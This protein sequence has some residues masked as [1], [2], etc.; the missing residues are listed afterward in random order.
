M[1][2][3][4]VFAAAPTLLL[5]VVLFGLRRELRENWRAILFLSLAV[6]L[7]FRRMIFLP[8]MI[9]QSDAN[10][11]Q[12]QFFSVYREAITGGAVP[13]WNHY[14]GAGLPNL[15]HPLSAM[16][17]PLTPLFLAGSVFKAMGGFIALH[18]LLAGLFALLLGRRIFRTG[19]AALAFALLW[20]FNGWAVT[21]AGHQPAIEYLFA[22]AWLPMAALFFERALDGKRLLSSAAGAG[23]GLAWMGI[24][25]PNLFVHAC[26]LLG[27][28]GILRVAWLLAGGRRNAAALA[29]FLVFTAGSFAVALSAVEI[30]PA[31]ELS[32]LATR[33]RLGE[34]FPE[35]WRGR[36]LSGWEILRLYFPYAPDRPFAVYYSPGVLALVGALYA[37]YRTVRTGTR[38]A[39][40]VS[41][42]ALV[43]LGAALVSKG[44]LY[45]GFAWLFGLYARASL[46]PAGLLL[47][48]APVL[49]LAALGVEALI[50]SRR[51]LLGRWGWVL[52]LLV[53]AE[54]FTV[55]SIIYPRRGERRLTYDYRREVADFPHL[56]EVAHSGEPGRT[57]VHGPRE[58]HVL[59]PSY[60]MFARGLRR[61]NLNE[62][63]FAP[64][65]LTEMISL[66]T[67]ELYAAD[68]EVLGV[69]FVASTMDVPGADPALVVPWPGC[70]DHFENSLWWPLRNRPAWLAWDRT[71]RLYRVSDEPGIFRV[72]RGETLEAVLGGETGMPGYF[73]SWELVRGERVSPNRLEI[74]IPPAASGE[75]EGAV[76]FAALTAY[77]GWRWRADGKDADWKVA[78]GGL[79]AARIEEGAGR[80]ELS[81]RPTRWWLSLAA[82][83]GA[84]LFALGAALL[85]ERRG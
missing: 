14:Q 59:A 38:R 27:A 22:Y 19:P 11:L 6:L 70:M 61:L 26:I 49:A 57:A 82:S 18:C 43:A 4:I 58:G 13:F 28:A 67:A 44:P 24:A 74:D 17:Y 20:A 73:D 47:L 80:L 21:R 53:F 64:D 3:A 69:G 42:V 23:A 63:M 83:L 33:G 7:F 45:T 41:A 75:G 25:C 76:V 8:E 31:F 2:E 78:G 1:V 32:L 52:A 60:A 5:A 54:L 29:L 34:V 46:M 9:S 48:F 51:R 30:V 55:F 35:G 62:S 50:E 37:L 40:A 77:P 72:K 12:L 79:M 39:L 84:V 66:V 56:D 15:A 81:F 65:A 36:G 68:L 71:V 10:L 85:D 16:W